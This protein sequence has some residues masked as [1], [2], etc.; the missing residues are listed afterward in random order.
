MTDISLVNMATAPIKLQCC[1]CNKERHTYKC[2]GCAKDFCFNH[3]TEHRQ[4]IN[5]QFDEIENDHDQFRQ[6]LIE[7][8]NDSARHPLIEDINRWEEESIRMI[9]TT[10]DKCR[11]RLIT[12]ADHYMIEI[13]KQLNTLARKL[14]QIRQENEFNEIDLDEI[15]DKFNSLTE[16]LNT[17]LN[18]SIEQ[19]STSFLDKMVLIVPMEK[20][21]LNRRFLFKFYLHLNFSSDTKWEQNGI[22]IAGGNK[23]GNG[24]NQLSCPFGICM[25]NDRTIYVTD[26]LN[27]RIVEWKHNGKI[28]RIVAGGNGSGK[29]MNQLNCPADV[30][31][32]LENNSLIIADYGNRR[33]VRWSREN[34]TDGKVLISDIDC[35]RLTMD[36]HG[37]LY[38]SDT[39]RNEV[40]RW[41]RGDE[42]GTIVAGG[43]GKGNRLNQFDSPGFIFID[44]EDSLYISDQ[45]NHRVMKWFNDAREGIIIAG[46]NNSG[47]EL[48]QISYPEGVIADRFGQVYIADWDNDRLVR[49][50]QGAKV[51]TMILGQGKGHETNQLNGPRGL[52]FDHQGNFYVAD[53]RNHRIQ[54]FDID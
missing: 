18:I 21:I 31:V 54:K 33:V 3:L 15:K 45:N 50:H 13:E 22:T 1:I 53:S 5:R 34:C 44:E 11:R 42:N 52:L 9:K 10:A 17:P 20:G 7:R 12:Y 43:N 38:V 26:C 24:L 36:K 23:Q 19:E 46:G 4:M 40:R 14:Q 49:W 41:K 39:K 29:Q 48:T 32:D 2:G 51:G 37:S 35:C 16:E 28:G 30:I 8:K 6:A 27:H 25:D 47:K